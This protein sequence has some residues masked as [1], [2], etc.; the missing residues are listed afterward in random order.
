[1]S[2][3]R[4]EG[5]QDPAKPWFL[6]GQYPTDFMDHLIAG[7]MLVFQR[8]LGPV[9]EYV[10]PAPV[11]VSKVLNALLPATVETREEFL[12][13]ES[14]ERVGRKGQT[15]RQL[16]ETVTEKWPATDV[17]KLTM[18]GALGFPAVIGSPAVARMLADRNPKLSLIRHRLWLSPTD[19]AKTEL[20]AVTTNGDLFNEFELLSRRARWTRAADKFGHEQ[21][22]LIELRP[23]LEELIRAQYREI[24]SLV[25]SKVTAAIS[26]ASVADK[27]TRTR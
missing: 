10:R 5:K 14:A 23:D 2:N 27:A 20:L 25:S 12:G 9:V 8:A 19:G 11:A 13:D 7:G 15:A 1:M 3:A 22:V 16:F 24:G 4:F 26:T 21:E 18:Y 17:E 6:E